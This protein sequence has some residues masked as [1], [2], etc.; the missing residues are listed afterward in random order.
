MLLRMGSVEVSIVVPTYNERENIGALIDRLLELFADRSFEVLV[1]D[2]SSP[3]GTGDVVSS[4]DDERVTLLSR[5]EKNGI[6]AALHAGYD[7]AQ[8]TYILSTDADFSFDPKR[9]LDILASLESGYD[10]VVANRHSGG[11]VYERRNARV[12]IKGALSRS[13]NAML[14]R[15]LGVP[16]DDLSANFRGIGS[17]VW[18]SLHVRETGNVMLGEMI[19]RA[20]R[21][22][23]RVGQIP[24]DFRDRVQGESKTSL[25][26][27][28][29]RFAWRMLAIRFRGDA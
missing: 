14:T 18:R 4:Y 1:V 8:G 11:A 23:Y 9:L 22:G 19:Y 20:H 16:V 17:E 21:A 24:I 15:L 29:P 3:D 28:I 27:E 26:R 25:V 2:D 7:A 5:T 6:G 10:L 13:G 12:K